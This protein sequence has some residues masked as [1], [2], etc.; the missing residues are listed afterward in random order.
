M[1]KQRCPFHSKELCLTIY[2]FSN[3]YRCPERNCCVVDMTIEQLNCLKN[4]IDEVKR[5]LMK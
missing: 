2:M 3:T 1:L 4:Q 5:S